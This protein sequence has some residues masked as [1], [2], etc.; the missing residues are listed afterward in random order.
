MDHPPW[1]RA[2]RFLGWL[3]ANSLIDGIAMYRRAPYWY[4]VIH[5][6]FWPVFFF[7]VERDATAYLNG[8]IIPKR[9]VEHRRSRTPCD[10]LNGS[11]RWW[12]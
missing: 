1:E 12:S 11:R 4:V 2:R 10:C 7:L 6:L 5:I 9:C 3:C 8:P